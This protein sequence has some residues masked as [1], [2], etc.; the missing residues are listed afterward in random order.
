MTLRSMRNEII[1]H[2]NVTKRDVDSPTEFWRSA[3]AADD[4]EH[5]E[6]V[7]EVDTILAWPARMRTR[8]NVCPILVF[9]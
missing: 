7:W 4:V 6:V 8:P 5:A 3:G 2:F 9:P 1:N